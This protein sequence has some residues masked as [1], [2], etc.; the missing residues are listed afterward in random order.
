M[1][2][3]LEVATKAPGACRETGVQFHEH[4]SGTNLFCPVFQNLQVAHNDGAL[5][6]HEIENPVICDELDQS[7]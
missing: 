2:L 3:N 7:D 6:K 5:V 4:A 1:S